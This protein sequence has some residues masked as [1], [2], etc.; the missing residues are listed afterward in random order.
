LGHFFND[1]AVKAALHA[2]SEWQDGNPEVADHLSA[3]I[4]E[5]LVPLMDTL[6]QTGLKWLM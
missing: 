5:G 2:H 6:V 4:V 3:H 1:P